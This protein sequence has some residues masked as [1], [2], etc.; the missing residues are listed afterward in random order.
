MPVT[1]AKGVHQAAAG[2]IFGALGVVGAPVRV[3]HDGISRA[4]YWSVDNGL[5]APLVAGARGV[6]RRAG[7]LPLADSPVGSLLLGAINGAIGDSL[8][9]E[10]RELALE[11]SIR[12][13]G[14]AVDLDAAGLAGSFPD[15]TARLAVF[16]HGLCETEDAWRIRPPSY[17]SR[18]RDEL[19]YTPVYVRYN[20]GLR[21]SDNGRRLAEVVERVVSDWPVEVEEIALI[22]HSMGGLV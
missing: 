21:V 19:G 8:A 16:V 18:L 15:A 17:G 22:G 2:R 7:G 9:R 5:R 6:A 20:T 4:V 13:Q 10:H 11:L 12:S 3:M 14:R 1:L